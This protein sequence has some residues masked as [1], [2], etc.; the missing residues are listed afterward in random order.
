MSNGSNEDHGDITKL[1]QAWSSG[2][3]EALDALIP[4]VYSEIH[5]LAHAYLRREGPRRKLQTT[6]LVNEASLQL[7]RQKHVRW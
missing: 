1:L 4:V 6:E 3:K 5:R 7:V 2:D